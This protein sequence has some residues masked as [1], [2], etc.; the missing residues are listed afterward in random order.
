[1]RDIEQIMNEL[2]SHPD[3]AV[4]FCLTHDV[5]GEREPTDHFSFDELGRVAHETALAY[6]EDHTDETS[7]ASA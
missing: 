3:C 7:R 2:T 4:A 5:F 1:M 6:I